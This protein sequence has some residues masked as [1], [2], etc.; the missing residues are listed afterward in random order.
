MIKI[1]PLATNCEGYQ[2][3]DTLLLSENA[4]ADVV[5]NLE[6]ANNE[7]KCSHG[8]TITQIDEEKLFYMMSR[9]LDEKNAKKTMIE[10]FFDPVFARFENES[11]KEEIVK[12]ITE[13][14][15]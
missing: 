7:V 10:G 12:T 14:L 15:Q 1:N 13:R 9:G 11:I 2:K 5:P 3:D 6:I 4:R 8:A